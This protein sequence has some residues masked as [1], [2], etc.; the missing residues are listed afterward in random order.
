MTPRPKLLLVAALCTIA[1]LTIAARF[2]PKPVSLLEKRAGFETQLLEK[3]TSPWSLDTPPKGVLNLINYDTSIGE[4]EAYV[5]PAPKKGTRSPAIIWL[6]GGFP[7]SSPGSWLWDEP[8]LANEQIASIY[9]DS[10]IVTMYP[11][12]RGRSSN[13][14]G[15]VECFYG[16]VNDVIDAHR[17]LSKLD[18]VDPDK[19][20]LG[21]HSTGGTLALLVAA[22]TDVFAGVISLGPTQ[23]DYGQDYA[24]YEWTEKERN[25]RAPIH[26][27]DSIK[28]ITYIIEGDGGN[29]YSLQML[30]EENHNPL[31]KII[32]VRDAD[33]FQII[34]PVNTIFANEINASEDGSLSI[35]PIAIQMS[36]SN[37]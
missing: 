3:E 4:M 33:H 18:Y 34:H 26:H 30:D 5:S 19:I 27:L 20:Y 15:V 2:Q 12:L 11:A 32:A 13:N 25:L 31:V 29:Y 21:G 9:R 6:S 23:D 8:K 22:A 10:G 14:P 24:P 36:V 17:Y 16:E 35:D 37:P 28:S 1:A 7:G